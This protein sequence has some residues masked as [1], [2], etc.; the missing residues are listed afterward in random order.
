MNYERRSELRRM[1]EASE[2]ALRVIRKVETELRNK[3]D[4]FSAERM[5]AMFEANA[6]ATAATKTI[7]TSL[8]TELEQLERPSSN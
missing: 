6:D 7:I 5:H 1:I 2:D 3:P 4:A 8:K